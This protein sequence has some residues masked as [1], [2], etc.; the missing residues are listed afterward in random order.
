MAKKIDPKVKNRVFT[1][2]MRINLMK[3]YNKLL[4]NE[5]QYLINKDPQ[6]FPN[7]KLNYNGMRN[8]LKSRKQITE[9]NKIKEQAI[10]A[11][12][13]M[14]IQHLLFALLLLFL[15]LLYWHLDCILSFV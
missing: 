5:L 11:A 1:I 13:L 10:K 7:W 2:L 4:T 6:V 14:F 8:I 15:F 9:T 12:S 3:G